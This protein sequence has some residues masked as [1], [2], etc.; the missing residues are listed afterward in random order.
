[1]SAATAIVLTLLLVWAGATAI[2]IA[3]SS[4]WRNRMGDGA[5]P[6]L[7]LLDSASRT[8]ELRWAA[9][10]FMGHGLEGEQ[11]QEAVCQATNCSPSEATLAIATAL[12]DAM[13]LH[14]GSRH[15]GG[16]HDGGPYDGEPPAGV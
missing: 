1:M 14:D 3:D 4:V 16:R 8:E 11:L 9:V 15:D 12:N 5:P 10:R 13:G 2:I 7:L 6:N